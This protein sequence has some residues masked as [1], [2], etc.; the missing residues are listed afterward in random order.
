MRISP[1]KGEAGEMP[2]GVDLDYTRGMVTTDMTCPIKETS[3]LFI[4]KDYETDTAGIPLNDYIVKQV[5]PD[6]NQIAFAIKKV[7]VQ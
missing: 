7:S 5:A 2:F 1:N 6:I 3:L 4:D